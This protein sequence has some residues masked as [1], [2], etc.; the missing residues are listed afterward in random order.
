MAEL[1][2]RLPLDI[3]PENR[4]DSTAKD[5]KLVNAF[6]EKQPDGSVK[7]FKRPGLSQVYNIGGAGLGTY[8]WLGN[9]YSVF[10][11]A[12]YKNTV[13][14]G[15]VD[16][17]G[18]I[19]HWTQCLG[20]TPKLVLGNGVKA[21]TYDDSNGLVEITDADFPTAFVK[22]WAYLNGTTYVMTSAA[23]IQGSEINDPQNWDPLNVIIAQ[24]EPDLGVAMAKQLSYA[25]AM[26]EWSTETFYDAGNATGSPLGR[27][28][29]AKLN[30][31][32]VAADSVA[33]IDGMLLWLSTNRSSSHEVIMMDNLKAKIV[34]D[35]PIE[36][37]LDGIDP[38]EGNFYAWA[39]KV[40]GHRFYVLTV[41]DLNL[42]LYYDIDEN[43]WGQWTD[44]SGNY[45]PIVAATYGPGPVRILQHETNGKLYAFDADTYTDD[46][47]LITVDVVTPNFDGGTRVMKELE[48]MA[49]A[50]NQVKGSKLHV[51]WN[52]ADYD[53]RQ[54]SNFR[55][56][57]LGIEFPILQN[58]GSFRR[59]AFHMR[60]RA[61]TAWWMQAVDLSLKMGTV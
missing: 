47:S 29:G 30:Y 26:K 10:G 2:K 16:A 44:A 1:P 36:R 15:T 25:I 17:T 12:L 52:D 45:F 13:S 3:R 41:M 54:W 57:D 32:C 22:G 58:C 39:T 4:D 35:K 42:T 34:S 24:I 18:G 60:H 48:R 40:D 53:P 27:V 49:F 56:V 28:E 46:S 7:L 43:R 55:D 33:E 38:R 14:V 31:G 61:N 8:N 9:I 59:R 11:T 23:E 50:A 21:Y 6:A 19:Y 51:R 37:L 5:A 20:D